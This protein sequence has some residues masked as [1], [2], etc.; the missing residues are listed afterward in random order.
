[1]IQAESPSFL[2]S[3][4]QS[5]DLAKR[6]GTSAAASA[7]QEA[8]HHL[9][10]VL[11]V[12]GVI[13]L[14]TVT[15]R[16][17][18]LGKR[19][20]LAVKEL[21]YEKVTSLLT[22]A[23]RDFF[24]TLREVAQSEDLAVFTKVRLSDLVKVRLGIEN[25]QVLQNRIQQKHVDFVLCSSS[26]LAPVLVVEL[27]DRSHQLPRRQERDIL[28]DRIF[29]SADLPILRIPVAHHYHA[30]ELAAQIRARLGLITTA[31]G[32]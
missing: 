28:V 9:V 2:G 10:V 1:M 32:G 7:G 18:R 13:I 8:Y 29:A 20:A 16:R 14:A 6:R 30:E 3:A 15:F 11:I 25:R 23:E 17:L 22:P 24:E 21:P 12:I 26:Q 5:R 27:D 4:G 19:D 31:P